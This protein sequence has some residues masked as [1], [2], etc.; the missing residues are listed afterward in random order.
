MANKVMGWDLVSHLALQAHYED[1]YRSIPPTACPN[2][3]EPMRLGPS[4][5]P[6]VWYC[7]MDGFQYPRDWDPQIHSGM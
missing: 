6:G 4:S 2:D 7:P 3:G 5:R 1:Y